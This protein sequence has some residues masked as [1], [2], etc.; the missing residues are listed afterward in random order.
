[1]DA[2]IEAVAEFFLDI[3]EGFITKRTYKSSQVRKWTITF[4]YSL[5]FLL[6]VGSWLV[7]AIRE[8]Q[9]GE[10]ATPVVSGILALGF[11]VAGLI[12]VIRGHRCNWKKG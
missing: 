3:M 4:F 5:I 8:Y 9:A 10:S 6:F 7:L 2:I 12:V 11:L 1:M